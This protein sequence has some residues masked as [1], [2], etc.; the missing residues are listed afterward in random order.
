MSAVQL[1]TPIT[2]QLAVVN[3]IQAAVTAGTDWVVNGTG[4]STA[5]FKW[6]EV[7]PASGSS[8][9]SDY[10]ILFVERVNTTTNKISLGGISSA[11]IFAGTAYACAC[12]APDGGACT[13]TPANIETANPVYVGTK[14]WNS[15]GAGGS[16]YWAGIAVQSTAIWLYTGDGAMWVTNRQTAT[17]HNL[18]A[19]GHIF[20]SST[21]G[22]AYNS[23]GTEVGI[24]GIYARVNTGSTSMAIGLYGFSNTNII[25][26]YYSAS[27]PLYYPKRDFSSSPTLIVGNGKYEAGNGAAFSPP[28][29]YLATQGTLALRGVFLC[30]Y[31]KT[32][33][34]I[35]NSAAATIGYTF[36]P[37]DTASGLNLSA[38]CFM[39]S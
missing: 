3:A 7:K 29:I 18:V 24:P 31:L 1:V 33:T 9:Y 36:Y 19:M 15:A 12:F 25:Q 28:F 35:Q 5:G 23:A 16:I 27:T 26:W 17:T 20:Y 32:R 21:S 10:R 14:F 34:T 2:S 37:D 11:S 13:F 4:T 22:T 38:L 30:D 6:L 8:L 39:S